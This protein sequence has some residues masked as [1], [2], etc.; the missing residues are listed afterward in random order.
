MSIVPFLQGRVF[1]PEHAQVMGLA[2]DKV[3]A[4]LHDRGQPAVVQEIIIA[5]RI[6]DLA[7]RGERDP[8]RLAQKALQALGIER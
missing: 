7:M 6:V 1:S 5:K 8:D 4:D 3:C 2:F